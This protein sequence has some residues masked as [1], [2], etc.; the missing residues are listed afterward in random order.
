MIPDFG[1]TSL[2]FRSVTLSGLLATMLVAGSFAGRGS[3]ADANRA[4][5]AE[6]LA[7]RREGQRR[8]TLAQLDRERADLAA[9]GSGST[10]GQ[11]RTTV[12]KHLRT[13]RGQAEFVRL[14]AE[15]VASVPAGDFLPNARLSALLGV[16]GRL[17]PPPVVTRSG[18][19]GKWRTRVEAGWLQCIARLRDGDL[20]DEGRL[21]ELREDLYLWK[22]SEATPSD[23]KQRL[24]LEG[25]FRD[26]AALVEVLAETRRAERLRTRLAGFPGGTVSDLVGWVLDSDVSVRPGTA[27]HGHLSRVSAELVGRFDRNRGRIADEGLNSDAAGDSQAAADVPPDAANPVERQDASGQAETFAIEETPVPQRKQSAPR[28]MPEPDLADRRHAIADVA[29]RTQQ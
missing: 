1:A 25:Y 26:L 13:L 14:L 23:R 8:Q 27:A 7:A 2:V 5:K 29:A 10:S 21:R 16:D 3:A 22:Q 24:A 18:P 6:Q 17:P 20:P 11:I 28:L 9:F 4:E 12:R 19:Q 15:S